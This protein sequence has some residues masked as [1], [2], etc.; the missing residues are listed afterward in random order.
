MDAAHAPVADPPPAP[1]PRRGPVAVALVLAALAVGAALAAR[2]F[3][4]AGGEAPGGEPLPFLGT[5]PPFSFTERS[6]GTVT[7]ADLLGRT[8]VADFIFTNCAGP[9]PDMSR[10]MA[11]L[12]AAIAPGERAACVSFT[13]D[14]DRDS[15]EVL[16]VYADRHRA[17]PDRWLFLR[18]P[19]EEVHALS[20]RGF[21]LGDEKDPLA[22][23]VRFV[24][25]DRRGVVRGFYRG[26]DEEHVSRLLRDFRRLIDADA[27]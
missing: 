19:E 1:P 3:E 14:P 17:S 20:Y 5:V 4:P 27:P 2:P 13:V 6:G 24:L 9:C 12:H 15:L 11:G 25:V 7:D 10:R 16:R 18:G 23:S 22:H 8:W 26:T 21:R